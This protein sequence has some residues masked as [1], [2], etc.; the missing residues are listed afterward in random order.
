MQGR[1]LQRSELA[2]AEKA[3]EFAGIARKA[4]ESGDSG[5]DRR[6]SETSGGGC[7]CRGGEL[8]RAAESSGIPRRIWLA[9]RACPD[10]GLQ[11]ETFVIF[12]RSMRAR[13]IIHSFLPWR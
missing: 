4:W 6:G 12:D 7:S 2:A 8:L 5:A 13:G 9:D 11:A 1:G 3:E 10:A